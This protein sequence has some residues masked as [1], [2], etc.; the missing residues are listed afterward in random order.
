MKG[1]KKHFDNQD[2]MWE[3][4]DLIKAGAQFFEECTFFV[5]PLGSQ[6]QRFKTRTFHGM[7]TNT[8]MILRQQLINPK[9]SICPEYQDMILLQAT[10]G[11]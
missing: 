3:K 5:S 10:G 6:Q 7:R 2:T 9:R 11:S 1:F 8:E 4:G